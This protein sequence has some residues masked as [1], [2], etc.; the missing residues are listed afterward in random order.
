MFLTLFE[1][2][3]YSCVVKAVTFQVRRGDDNVTHL[4][5]ALNVHPRL[6]VLLNNL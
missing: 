4:Y 5:Q 3:Q 1:D 2:Y 6:R